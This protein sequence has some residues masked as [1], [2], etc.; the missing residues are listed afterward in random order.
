MEAKDA[1]ST[2]DHKPSPAFKVISGVIERITYQDE[3]SGYTIARLLPDSVRRSSE[4]NG[5]EP[6]PA[7]KI[8]TGE[9]HLVTVIGTLL[10][11]VAGEALELTG[12]WQHHSKHG[13]QFNVQNYRSVLPATIQGLR[14]YLGSGLIKGIGPRTAEKIVARFDLETLDI[15]ESQQERLLEVPGLGKKRAERIATAWEEQKA[16]KEVMVCLQGLGVSTSLAVRI[17]KEYGEKAITIVKN[18]PYRLARDV[19]GIGF[20]TADKIAQGLGYT[21]DHPERIKAGVLFVLAEASENGGH[22]YLPQQELTKQSIELLGVRNDQVEKAIEGLRLDGGVL[23]D[24]LMN[25]ANG[26]AFF[27]PLRPDITVPNDAQ[28]QTTEQQT[29]TILAPITR[30]SRLPIVAGKH[31]A[32]DDRSPLAGEQVVYL[33]P[34]YAAEQGIA[35]NLLRLAKVPPE[36]GRLADLQQT[37]FSVMFDYLATKADLTLAERQQ[38][39]IMLALTHPVAILTGGP[40]TGKTTSLRALIRVLTLKKKQVILAAPTGRA[41]KRLS[42]TTGLA[43]KTLH[44]LLQLRPGGQSPYDRNNPLP[45]DIV[46][47]DEVSMLDTLLMNTLLKT[48]ATGT[49]LLL[50]GDADQLPS[51]GAGKVLADLIS[52]GVVPAVHL[53]HIFRQ[54]AG[55]QI[56]LNAQRINEGLLP[57]IG[58]ENTEFYLFSQEDAGAASNLIIELV[59]QR[60]PAK[61]GFRPDEIQVLSPMHRG[62]CGV[63]ELNMR[64][65]AAI[66]PPSDQKAERRYGG[67]CFR[68]GDKVLQL[69]NNYEKEVFNGDGGWI[70]DISVEDQTLTVRLDDERKVSYEFG[71][72]DELMLAYAISIHKAQGSEYPACVIPLA[73]E[74]YLLLERKLV[75][76]GV[77]RARQLVV[78]VG[79]KKAL[80]IA[81]RNG[82]KPDLPE[83]TATRVETANSSQRVSPARHRMERYTGLAIRLRT[84][85]N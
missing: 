66:N 68:V 38:D 72:L 25:Q 69:R 26:Q 57:L 60:I 10:G 65:Q 48:I 84:L 12:F 33:P 3:E 36:M 52:S 29:N 34:F 78:L 37:N 71:E 5:Q 74:Q 35:R 9:D 64:L 44:R 39:G 46:I 82:P 30:Q 85:Q 45:T 51:V 40:G 19:W 58:T 49:H 55:S 27:L 41:A 61:F 67:M 47:V 23:V 59:A 16:I 13:W 1:T 42:E 17:Y 4:G 73:M 77:T 62:K 56:A 63:G 2:K 18:E 22:T 8:P 70:T 7:E 15:L 50:V 76:T 83:E 81:I 54:S 11:A 21:F 79:S 43:A 28:P 80:S 32:S 24:S 53:D 14:K 31:S 20:K 75:Y 6:Q